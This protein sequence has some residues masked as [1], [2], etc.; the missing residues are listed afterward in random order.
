MSGELS[1][2]V[3]DSTAFTRGGPVH[4]HRADDGE[5]P[6]VAVARALAAARNEP[7]TATSTRLY[8]HV[9]PDA[10]DALFDDWGSAC[11]LTNVRLRIEEYTVEVREHG[12][13]VVRE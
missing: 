1:D 8:D 13:V 10:L 11:G 2:A 12:E 4:R 5:R 6:S 9:D 3:C 7:P